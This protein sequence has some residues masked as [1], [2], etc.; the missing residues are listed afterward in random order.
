[1]SGFRVP[2]WARLLTPAQLLRLADAM[3]A[4]ARA[5]RRLQAFLHR[6]Q[7]FNRYQVQAWSILRGRPV[8]TLDVATVQGTRRFWVVDQEYR[9]RSPI[10][11][12][13]SATWAAVTQPEGRH[14]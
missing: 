2:W 12:D 8:P 3:L 9:E 10:V 11:D 4:L 5:V 1:M 7:A 6:L 14:V 13:A